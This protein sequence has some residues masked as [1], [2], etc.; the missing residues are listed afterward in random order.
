MALS[1]S[2][3]TFEAKARLSQLIDRV[4]DGETITITRHGSP[5]ARLVPVS[6]TDRDAA[7]QAL[8]IWKRLRSGNRVGRGA[9]VRS[10][11]VQGRR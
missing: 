2:F 11:K 4:V 6:G 5:V 3:G 8:V 10:L 7:R 1:N 9:S